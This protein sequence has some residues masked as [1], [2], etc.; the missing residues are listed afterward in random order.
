MSL[1]RIANF[2]LPFDR[3]FSPCA[4]QITLVIGSHCVERGIDGL[5]DVPF[6][7]THLVQM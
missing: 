2:F 4:G 1:V 6:Y 3:K 5:I 7:V